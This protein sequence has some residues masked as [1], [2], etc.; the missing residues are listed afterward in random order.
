MITS[1]LAS[2][3]LSGLSFLGW[4]FV[5]KSFF[6]VAFCPVTFRPGL[7]LSVA[8]CPVALCP[9][10]VIRSESNIIGLTL[11]E[12]G[13]TINGAY[14]LQKCPSGRLSCRCHGLRVYPQCDVRLLIRL[15]LTL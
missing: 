4:H 7:F 11:I 15:H 1:L 12:V 5:R 3:I 2:G 10:T 14:M 13:W 6:R 9:Y 8:F